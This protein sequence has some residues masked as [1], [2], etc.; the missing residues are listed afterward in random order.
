MLSANRTIKKSI[1][2]KSIND[3][4]VVAI[5]YYASK[6][7]LLDRFDEVE[8]YAKKGARNV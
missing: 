6:M 1:D 5:S 3:D 2:T 7:Y 4:N 8:I